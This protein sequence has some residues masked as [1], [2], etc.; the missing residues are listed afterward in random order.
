[1]VSR[2]VYKAAKSTHGTGTRSSYNPAQVSRSSFGV[3]SITS[4]FSGITY[5]L[6]K[7]QE[8]KHK[9]KKTD[10]LFHNVLE[11]YNLLRS[12][13]SDAKGKVNE[14]KEPYCVCETYNFVF[15]TSSWS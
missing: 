7:D 6:R 9:T 11:I 2:G 8:L 4:S 1:M 13:S 3:D 5:L 15:L 14:K 12:F 10:V